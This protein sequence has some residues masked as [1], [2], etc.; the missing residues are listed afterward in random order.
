MAYKIQG[1]DSDSFVSAKQKSESKNN[2]SSTNKGN[3][4]T[5]A[6]MGVLSS[7]LDELQHHLEN[8]HQ[9]DNLNIKSGQ[10]QVSAQTLQ[11]IL[12]EIAALTNKLQEYES[13][14]QAA[15]NG[16]DTKIG[17]AA[18]NSAIAAAKKLEHELAEAAKQKREMKWLGILADVIEGIMFAVAAITGQVE[19]CIAMMVL[20]AATESGGTKDFTKAVAKGL[21]K[22]GCSPKLANILA[23]AITILAE[24]VVTMGVCSAGAAVQ[25]A[26]V[27]TEAAVKEVVES[28]VK[29]AVEAAV[30]DAVSSALGEGTEI[31]SDEMA[32]IIETAAKEA[33]EDCANQLA[34]DGLGSNLVN[35]SVESG[36]KDGI[37]SGVKQGVKAATEEGVEVSSSAAK[38]VGKK[39]A[40]TLSKKIATEVAENMGQVATK[41]VDE[42]PE[43]LQTDLKTAGKKIARDRLL[44]AVKMTA[45]AGVSNS[46]L[47]ENLAISF[48]TLFPKKDQQMVQLLMTIILSL[49]AM[50]A[51]IEA[52]TS[53][54]GA[55][56]S[57]NALEEGAQSGAR[58]AEAAGNKVTK[59][60]K[61]VMNKITSN[62]AMM[63]SYSQT[64]LGLGQSATDVAMATAQIQISKIETEMSKDQPEMQ[65]NNAIAKI[66]DQIQAEDRKLFNELYKAIPNIMADANSIAAVFASAAQAL[67]S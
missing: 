45:A 60:I 65:E 47:A 41:A 63:L 17:Q 16:I 39:L 21:E 28:A 61:D 48:S 58:E 32:T 43:Q 66:Q 56:N 12:A 51:T 11:D 38:D 34:E 30:K 18:I 23:S 52:G 3:K 62:P 44:G 10:N 15:K 7:N 46:G 40:K 64:T 4:P 53:M 14:F 24:V 42:L 55:S 19:L 50:V 8:S 1:L 2:N 67:A 37:Q 29:D 59:M 13:K 36:T 27:A 35:K 25:G 57:G 26:K 20:F 31:G 22:M 54:S 33:A 6:L 49:L 9:E 5:D